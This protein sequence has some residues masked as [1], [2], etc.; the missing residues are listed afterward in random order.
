M[1][2]EQ[3]TNIFVPSILAVLV[4]SLSTP[5]AKAQLNIDWI[6]ITSYKTYVDGTPSGAQPWRFE[7]WVE[8]VDPGSLDHIDVTPPFPA[9][10]FTMFED[11][12]SW[13]WEALSEYSSLVSLR[14]DYPEGIY[15]FDFRNISDVLLDFVSLNYSG[16]PGEPSNPVSF[17]Y[18]SVNGQFGISINPTFTW[19]VDPGAGDTLMMALEDS[20]TDELYWDEPVSMTTPSWTP[21]PLQSGLGH[22]LEVSVLKVKDWVGPD[23]PIATTDGGDDFGYSP[24]IEYLNEINFT[25]MPAIGT[26][27]GLIFMPPGVPDIG[28]SLEEG[29]L[30]YFVSS[31]PVLNLNLTTG[32]WDTVG[33]EGL[34]YAN[35]PFIYEL[36]PGD[37]WFAWP[38]E[39]GLWVYHFST[40][41][42]EVL[43]RIIP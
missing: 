1:F 43:P 23:W 14:G 26:L 25:T 21:G 28:Y 7:I 9:T 2:K 17:T 24:M 5:V 19:T 16:L 36:D 29:D 40:G 42:W 31:E 8:N 13:G 20:L 33:P 38:P 37:L 3:K 27:S 41:Q 18:P 39:S 4:I 12:G 6:C 35:W 34:V 32:E 11:N 22:R 15:T 30:L 10:P